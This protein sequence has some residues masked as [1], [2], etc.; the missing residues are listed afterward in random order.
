MYREFKGDLLQILS[1]FFFLGLESLSTKK[2]KTTTTTTTKKRASEQKE[3]SSGN[4]KST[5]PRTIS[6]RGQLAQRS[7]F[8]Q[9][10]LHEGV[11]RQTIYKWG[12][13]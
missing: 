3:Q 5:R 2:K 13:N 8:T 9:I 4:H 6:H 1:Y 7:T 11:S 12:L 10:P